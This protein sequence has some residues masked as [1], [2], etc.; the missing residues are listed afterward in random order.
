MR[1]SGFGIFLILAGALIAVVPQFILP[2][3]ES[4]VA[5]AS[6]GSVPMKCFWTARAELGT[7]ALVAFCGTLLC[8]CRDA[9]VRSGIAAVT[10]AASLLALAFPTILI[11]MCGAETMPCRMG[12]LP[13]LILLAVAAF[14]VSLA[15]CR[16][17]LCAAKKEGR[18]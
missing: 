7:G 10:S 5:T 14:F 1:R 13:A 3:C 11:G 12:A 8:V 6:G 18:G 17:F 9:D 15:A 16:S 4:G 2:V